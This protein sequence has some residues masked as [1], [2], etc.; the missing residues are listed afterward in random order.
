[1]REIKFKVW[2][3]EKKCMVGIF[4]LQN[5][6]FKFKSNKNYLY[7][8]YSGLK[9]KNGK[10]VYEG[11]LL[12][13]GCGKY[14]E[15]VFYNGKFVLCDKDYKKRIEWAKEEYKDNEFLLFQALSSIPNL[16]DNLHLSV[17]GNKF[18]NPDLLK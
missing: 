12:K 1:M 7:L 3:K 13:T 18:E 16:C 17:V 9:D 5:L 6:S 14:L 8:Q 15:V 10:E 2:D 11:D 4:N